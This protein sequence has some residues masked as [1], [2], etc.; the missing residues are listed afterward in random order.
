MRE[1][2]DHSVVSGSADG[3]ELNS[4]HLKE[5]VKNELTKELDS[6]LDNVTEEEYNA[7]ELDSILD[8][9]DE[10]D[11]VDVDFDPAAAYDAF[12]RAHQA[13]FAALD[14]AGETAAKISEKS[15]SRF[16]FRKVAAVAAAAAVLMSLMS[17]Q[18][19]GFDLGQWFARWTSSLFSFAQQEE[20]ATVGAYPIA[21]GEEKQYDSLQ[22]A[23]DDFGVKGQ[24]APTVV[25]DGFETEFVDARVGTPGASFRAAYISA[26][27]NRYSIRINEYD[28][29]QSTLVEKDAN[30]TEMYDR[31]K[32][33]HYLISDVKQNKATWVN[34]ELECK[35]SGNVSIDEMKTLIDSIYGG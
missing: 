17:V 2:R 20:Y 18:A 32:I 29:E 10:V 8:A 4:Q 12:R 21:E 33:L 30:T 31:G 14:A 1:I 16:P 26:D 27:G 28:S 3:S 9:L 22:A 35:I 34:G 23:L 15:H 25:L 24:V 7:A 11:P 6:F 13:E 19:S 5:Y